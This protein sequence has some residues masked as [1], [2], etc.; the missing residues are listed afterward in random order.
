MINLLVA[1]AW[2]GTL[3]HGWTGEAKRYELMK[4]A[5][6]GIVRCEVG[7]KNCE[8]RKGVYELPAHV[9]DELKIMKRLG[10]RVNFL[11]SYDNPEVYPENPLDPEAFGNW[12]CWLAKRLKPW[13]DDFEIYNEGWTFGFRKRYGDKWVDEFVKFTRHVA[14]KLHQARPDAT[15]VVAS[16]DGWC[17]LH[18]MLCQSIGRRGESVSFHPYIHGK[19]PRPERGELFWHDDGK[20]MWDISLSHGG[21][22]RFR[23]TEVGWTTYAVA[24]HPGEDVWFSEKENY[25]GV[26]FHAQ[27]RY[28]MRAFLIARSHG[29]EAV[30]QYDFHDDGPYRGHTEHN[31]GLVFEDYSPKPA[32]FAMKTLDRFF[33]AAKPLGVAVPGDR[34]KRRVYG[35]IASDG[36]PRYAAWAVEG[37]DRVVLPEGAAGMRI[38]DIYGLQKGVVPSSR[39]ILLAED[40]VYIVR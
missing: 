10:I 39:E 1:A 38:F 23:I 25:P 33:G 30:M 15:V 14:D 18:G 16:E 17:A 26:S 6:I 31:F 32:F 27:A 37:A 12:A 35:F 29:I 24:E 22:S 28:L 9:E 8:K 19:D 4:E 2:I 3:V 5:G 34:M 40:P 36:Q 11:L 13:V 20:S 21:A 7:W